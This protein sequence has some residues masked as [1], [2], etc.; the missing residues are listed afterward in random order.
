[1]GVLDKNGLSYLWSK[2]KAKIDAKADLV[3]THDDRYY[4]ESETSSLLAGKSDKD[5]NHD[6]IYSLVLHNHDD[7]YSKYSNEAQTT[8]E[9]TL[10]TMSIG[11]IRCYSVKQKGYVTLPS[12]GTYFVIHTYRI[13]DGDYSYPTIATNASGG[14]SVGGTAS[15]AVLSSGFAIR[16]T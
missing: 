10:S 15:D 5:H 2:I 11:E 1:M 6:G 13:G 12:E 14:S 9:L 4:T 16:I 8:G 3:H 7:V